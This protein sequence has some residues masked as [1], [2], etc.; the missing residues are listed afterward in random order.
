MKRY[1]ISMHGRKARR[2]GRGSNFQ[3]PP[4]KKAR[5]ALGSSVK[6]VVVILASSKDGLHFPQ[7]QAWFEW[8]Q[9]SRGKV[10]FAVYAEDH[11][12]LK[13]LCCSAKR[14]EFWRKFLCPVHSSSAWGEFSLLH[15]ELLALKW[16]RSRFEKAHW[17]YVVS[18]DS[19]PTKSPVAFVKGPLQGNSVIGFDPQ[20][21]FTGG[22]RSV[23]APGGLRI[24]E[25]SQWVVLSKRHVDCLSELLIPHLSEWKRVA[26][27]LMREWCRCIMAADEWVIGTILRG[28]MA[29]EE[30]SDDFCIMEQMFVQA[31]CG[32]CKQKTGHAKVLSGAEFLRWYKKASKDA[33]T[34]ALRKVRAGVTLTVVV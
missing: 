10:G 15:S 17:F 14:W 9:N 25:H 12:G 19:V 23:T 1:D 3:P 31:R 13:E 24:Y 18:G 5:K 29:D 30:W 28:T 21:K 22:C 32:R 7:Q 8:A 20:E 34:F 27:K 26:N 33:S 16:A 11:Q 2:R 6:A 4:V